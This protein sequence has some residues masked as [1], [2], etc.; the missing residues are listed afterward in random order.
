MELWH[1]QFFLY[2]LFPDLKHLFAGEK[3]INSICNRL[4]EIL[5]EIILFYPFEVRICNNTNGGYYTGI[6]VNVSK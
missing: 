6:T 2:P 5:P 1:K 4:I 3:T